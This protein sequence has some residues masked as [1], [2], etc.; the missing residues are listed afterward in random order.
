MKR[1]P[2]KLP[3][4]PAEQCRRVFGPNGDLKVLA[5]VVS[6][7]LIALVH[8]RVV[9]VLQE[10]TYTVPVS[11]KSENDLF[12]V[13]S[14]EP[15]AAQI[16]LRGT[17]DQF[18]TFDPARLAVEIPAKNAKGAGRERLKIRGSN[19]LGSGD[20]KIVD[21]EPKAVDVHYDPMF[22]WDMV[23][24]VAPPKLEGAPVQGDATVEMK[25]NLTVV[26]HGSKSKIL[27][28]REK[29]ILLP[30]SPVNV[31]GK[32]ESFDATVAI[33]VPPD[34]GITKVEP[35]TV[36]VRVNVRTTAAADIAED[37]SPLHRVVR[38]GASAA[39]GSGDGAEGAR[40]GEPGRDAA[41]EGETAEELPLASPVEIHDAPLPESQPAP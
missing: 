2:I 22:T 25:T 4:D 39:I 37:N 29:K 3:F 34:S 24:R 31:D 35:A 6:A 33:M 32:T 41:P 23:D 36:Q 7:L 14:F 1:F 20:L 18:A 9:S 11:V 21:V 5:V 17:Q 19:I 8:Q 13:F 30:T 12:A 38:G 15:E 28:F 16:S 40:S 27:A 10:R 26:V